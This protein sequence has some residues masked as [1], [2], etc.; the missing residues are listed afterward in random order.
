[1]KKSGIF[2][3]FAIAVGGT[4]GS[5]GAAYPVYNGYNQT[6]PQGYQQPVQY[7]QAGQQYIPA[8]TVGK[9]PVA[10]NSTRVTGALPRVG[11]N[12]TATMRQ[13]YQPDTYDR[14]SDSGLYIGLS[15]AYTTS[16]QGG[17][18]ADYYDE[19]N[20]YF[21]P[22][23]FQ[24]ANY[25]SNTVLPLQVSVGAAI[26]SDIRVDFSYTRYSGISY[27]DV[28]QTSDGQ[29]GFFDVPSTGGAI[30]STVTMLNLYYNLDSYTGFLASGSVRPYIGVGVG[31]GTNT[32]ADYLV[33]DK[34]FYSEVAVGSP[35]IA[36]QLT[37]TSDIY[38]Y[39]A[40]GTTE[41]LAYMLEGGVTTELEGG[42]KLDFFVRYSGLGKVQSSGSI[43]VSQT[44]WVGTGI[45]AIGESGAEQPAPY[46]AVYHYTNWFES[47][48]LATIDLGVRMRLQ[49]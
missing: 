43:V 16:I 28:V 20:A 49:F 10:A 27:P 25:K 19:K 45:G 21:A 1:M 2:A 8:N 34:N 12:N 47:G 30:S 39:H 36:G 24:Q 14:L 17:M 7:Q 15:I 38:A 35:S 22:G 4:A 40:G 3:L 31:I 11:S 13:Y 5:A 44:E 41:N 26:N 48:N 46:D 23:A 42:I 33:Y 9:M 32:I 6:A 18:N 29:G 37:A